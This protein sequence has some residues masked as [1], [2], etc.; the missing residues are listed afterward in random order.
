[1]M[2]TFIVTTCLTGTF[3]SGE[4][5]RVQEYITAILRL[6][7]CI[8]DIPGVRIILVEGN[9]PRKTFL[10]DFGIEILY[11]HHNKLHI[12]NYG[13]KEYLD[14]MSVIHHYQI[15]DD[16]MVVKITGRY[17]LEKDSHFIKV[18]KWTNRPENKDV[19]DC[20]IRYGRFERKNQ[21]LEKRN[22]NYCVSGLIGL[23][24]KYFK[25]LDFL[26]GKSCV[27]RHFEEVCAKVTHQI[28]RSKIAVFNDRGLGITICPGLIYGRRVLV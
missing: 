12:S 11:T 22:I 5:K 19:F 28:P 1:M 10:D 20:L 3:W 9:G 21:D 24:C 26:A 15:P 25:Q 23:R 27:D 7:E 13:L 6:Q 18:L 8:S 2:V 14:I 17:V 16:E 4:E